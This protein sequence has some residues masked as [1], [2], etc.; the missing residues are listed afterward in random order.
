MATI[1]DAYPLLGK[2]RGCRESLILSASVTALDKQMATFN[3]GPGL[4]AKIRK[5]LSLVSRGF[6]MSTLLTQYLRKIII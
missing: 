1:E 6:F 2:I 5:R 3:T 4:M